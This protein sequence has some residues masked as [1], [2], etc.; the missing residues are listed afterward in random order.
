MRIR[1]IYLIPALLALCCFPALVGAQEQAAETTGVS[2]TVAGAGEGGKIR[3]PTYIYKSSGNRDPFR[4]LIQVK[5][6]DTADRRPRTQLE[7]YN[8]SQM[9]L[10]AV[11]SDLQGA[12]ALIGLPDNKYYTV[13][14]GETIGLHDGIV[15]EIRSDRVVVEEKITDFRGYE[16]SQDVFIRLRNEGG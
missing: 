13:R 5:K 10:I 7:S 3:K 12:Y 9:K 15:T 1:H 4:S 11:V 6:E 8:L 16:K 2:N 14:V